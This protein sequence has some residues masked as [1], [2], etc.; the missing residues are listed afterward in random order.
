VRGHEAGLHVALLF[1]SKEVCDSAHGRLTEAGVLMDQLSTYSISQSSIHGLLMGYGH[2]NEKSLVE[3]LNRVL[4]IL[5][6]AI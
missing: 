6:L 3:A 4:K 1:P 5:A 2:L